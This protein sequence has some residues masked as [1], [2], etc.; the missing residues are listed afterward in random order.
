MNEKFGKEY[1]LCSKKVMTAVFEKGK[2]E[3]NYP[4]VLRYLDTDLKT[5]TC[6]QI[7]ISVPKRRFKKAVD[8]NRI[9][10]LIREAVRKNKH[11]IEQSMTENQPQLALF[12]I[13]TGN[14][15]EPYQKIYDKI[16]ALFLRLVKNRA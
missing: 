11:I 16:E 6:F 7:V 8:R 10:R 4:F 15:E 9:K 2:T 5:N 1:K 3:K 12:L 13:Y 14:K